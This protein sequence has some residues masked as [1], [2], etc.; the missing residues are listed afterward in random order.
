MAHRC[1][2]SVAWMTDR[3]LC[4]ST[5]LSFNQAYRLLAFGVFRH[6]LY[7]ARSAGPTA[8]SRAASLRQQ[9]SRTASTYSA[10]PITTRVAYACFEWSTVRARTSVL[11]HALG[12]H[13]A[14]IAMVFAEQ[15]Y[16]FL[17][18]H[19]MDNLKKTTTNNI[20]MRITGDGRRPVTQPYKAD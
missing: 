9:S 17:T 8:N 12:E 16:C 7:Q 19:A 4:T 5:R 1:N 13:F 14:S 2:V 20:C 18:A 3:M 11:T 15:R 6:Y 10:I